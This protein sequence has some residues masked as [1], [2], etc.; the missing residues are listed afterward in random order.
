MSIA[1]G[2]MCSCVRNASC[3]LKLRPEVLCQLKNISKIVQS[4]LP[5]LCQT[6]AAVV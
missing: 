3:M 4:N 6:T 5:Y 2:L 1:V